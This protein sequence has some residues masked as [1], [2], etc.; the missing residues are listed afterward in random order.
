MKK[1]LVPVMTLACLTLLAGQAW[2]FGCRR[3]RDSSYESSCCPPV[4]TC[5]KYEERT[6]TCYKPE[7]KEEKVKCVVRKVYCRVEEV[8]VKCTVMVPKWETVKETCRYLVPVPRTVE[9]EVVRCRY[10]AETR[11]DEC[12]G[13]TYTCYKPETFTEKVKCTVWDCKEETKDVMRKVCRWEPEV[14]EFKQRRVIPESREETVEM[15]RRYCVMRPYETKVKV[16]VCVPCC[17]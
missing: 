17:E 4:Q 13:C 1:L 10:V 11:T 14:R 16:A 15:V 8:P 6:V 5:V 2:S 12:T 7:W 9:R 3:C